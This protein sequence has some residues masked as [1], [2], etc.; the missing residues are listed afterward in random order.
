M[1]NNDLSTCSTLRREALAGLGVKIVHEFA[2]A[3]NDWQAV[4]PSLIELAEK[5]RENTTEV[6]HAV[7]VK[8]R[9]L[10]ED[11]R[12]AVSLNGRRRPCL[13]TCAYCQEEQ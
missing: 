8:A 9:K 12:A 10:A 5:T 1:E 2:K 7:I 3:L 4:P 6:Q 11:I 13:R